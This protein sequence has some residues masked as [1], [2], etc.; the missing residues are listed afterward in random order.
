V[1][2]GRRCKR[3]D[4]PSACVRK[5]NVDVTVLLFHNSIELVQIFQA[6]HV[7]RD[8]RNVSPDKGCSFFQVFLSSAS[9]HDVRTFF[10]EALGCGQ[11]NP[12]V[13]ACDYRNF[14]RQFLSVIITHIFS[15]LFLFFV[16]LKMWDLR[17]S[18]KADIVVEFAECEQGCDFFSGPI[19]C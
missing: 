16:I 5:E 3:R 15:S 9:D 17:F 18:Y 10:H 8:R 4:C 1:R 11:A 6:R 7:A 14:S 13:S 2:L 12:A 19:S